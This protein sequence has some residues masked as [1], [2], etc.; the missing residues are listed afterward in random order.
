FPIDLVNDI[1]AGSV[2]VHDNSLIAAETPPS[3][4]AGPTG[5]YVAVV[6]QTDGEETAVRTSNV[7]EITF[8]DPASAALSIEAVNPNSGPL[9]GGNEVV[10]TGAGF[11]SVVIPSVKAA[12]IYT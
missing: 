10:I 6:M 9:C 4:P 12:N 2:T 5:V 11:P 8:V 7:V 1:P 3:M